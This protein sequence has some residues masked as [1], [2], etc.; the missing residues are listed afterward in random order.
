MKLSTGTPRILVVD[1]EKDLTDLLVT[2]LRAE[3]WRAEPALDGAAAVRTNRGFRPDAVVLDRGLP[4]LEGLEVL[5]RLRAH[6]PDLP[7]LFLTARE[8]VEDRIAGLRAG[9]DDYVPKPFDLDEVVL[10]LR[11]LLRR[12]ETGR[13]G[14]SLLVVGDLTLDEETRRVHR[15]GTPVRLTGREFELL[16]YLMRH[17]GRVLGREELLD[18]VWASEDDRHPG[19]VESYVSY[20]RRKIERDRSVLIH[21]VRGVGYLMKPADARR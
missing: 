13:P 20:L 17:T 14:G 19:I 18:N 5:R 10:R 12:C 6:R 9:A 8:G 3:G 7:V 4:D 16:R 11:A 21:T 1:D 2:V 15:A